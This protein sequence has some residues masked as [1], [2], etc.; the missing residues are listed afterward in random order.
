MNYVFHHKVV[1]GCLVKKVSRAIL[2]SF[3]IESQGQFPQFTQVIARAVGKCAAKVFHCLHHGSVRIFRVDIILLQCI[4]V[5]K[6]YP[7]LGDRR[8]LRM[9]GQGALRQ[10][11]ARSWQGKQEYRLYFRLQTGY[12][13]NICLLVK[14]EKR[15]CVQTPVFFF[16]NINMSRFWRIVADAVAAAIPIPP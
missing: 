10:R 8:D 2:A 5:R 16:A 13:A 9:G 4:K 3:G 7:R 12:R 6:Q 15:A 1:A 14:T 11:R